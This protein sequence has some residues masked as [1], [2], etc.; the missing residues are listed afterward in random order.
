MKWINANTPQ[1]SRFLVLT[2]ATSVACDS[3]SEWF[4]ALTDRQSLYTIQ[5]QEWTLGDEFGDFIRR[6]VEVQACVNDMPSCLDDKAASKD[7]GY[8]YLERRLSVNNCTHLGSDSDFKYF[9]EKMRIDNRFD[10]AYENDG[11]VLFEVR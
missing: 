3:V 2:G 4:P 11:I 7:Y 10:V 9:L 6:S 1:G 5:G 8:V